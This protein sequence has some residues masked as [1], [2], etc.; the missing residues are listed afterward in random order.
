[1][2]AELTAKYVW[3]YLPMSILLLVN[4]FVFISMAKMLFK[5]DRNKRRL[6]LTKHGRQGDHREK[7]LIYAKLFLGFG[8]SWTFEIIAGLSS[9]TTD[10]SIWYVTDVLNMLQPVY[11]FI[12][13]VLKRSVINAV[14]GRDKKRP[15]KDKQR[16]PLKKETKETVLGTTSKENTPSN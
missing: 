3:F 2:F 12:I 14:L 6:G 1:M 11:V 8:F 13:F 9:S 5:L 10:E 15:M 7:F 4:G 16:K